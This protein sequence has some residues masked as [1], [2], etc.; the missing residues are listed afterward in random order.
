MAVFMIFYMLVI[1]ALPAH[2]GKCFS[3]VPSLFPLCDFQFLLICS[4]VF[5]SLNVTMCIII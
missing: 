3:F 5:R 2:G 4:L 1:I